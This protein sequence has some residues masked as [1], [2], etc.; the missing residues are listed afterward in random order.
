[1]HLCSDHNLLASGKILERAT[2]NL[3]ARTVRIDV[4][5]IKERDAKLQRP[6]DEGSALL[7]IKR[8]GMV[9]A[10]GS[11]V[12]HAAKAEARDLKSGVAKLSIIL[13]SYV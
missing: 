5:C 3:L 8:L 4:G 1:M 11:S 9:A 6:L 12:R 10:I 7:L 13:P 2:D